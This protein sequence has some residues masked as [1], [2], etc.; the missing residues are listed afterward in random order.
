MNYTTLSGDC[1]CDFCIE[2]KHTYS[3]FIHEANIS[4]FHHIEVRVW[5]GLSTNTP[6]FN[7]CFPTDCKAVDLFFASK[8]TEWQSTVHNAKQCRTESEKEKLQ[9]FKHITAEEH[10]CRNKDEIYT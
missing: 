1:C 9:T 5:Q 2:V 3:D 8:Q 10:D 7:G 4:H 6:A